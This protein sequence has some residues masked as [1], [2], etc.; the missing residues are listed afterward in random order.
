MLHAALLVLVL[1]VQLRASLII[2]YFP[3]L[4]AARLMTYNAARLQEE[5]KP[6]IK[7]AA[8]AKVQSSFSPPSLTLCYYFMMSSFSL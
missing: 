4:E 3:E 1:T 8:M 7:E 6:F 2:I 5:G